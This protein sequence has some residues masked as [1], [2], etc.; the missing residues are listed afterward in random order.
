[1]GKKSS[2]SSSLQRARC[3]Q[4]TV[5]PLMRNA[6]ELGTFRFLLCHSHVEPG[7]GR[8]PRSRVVGAPDYTDGPR[9]D[10]MGKTGIGELVWPVVVAHRG[11][12]AVLPENT[13]AAF[14]GA[15]E[16]GA[17]LVELDVRFTAD[18]ELV[19]V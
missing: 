13:V 2:G 17:D 3:T 5:H 15:V 11:A 14:E 7:R 6:P 1:M 4:S 8:P 18:D 10:T 16:V 12:S 19:V 9:A